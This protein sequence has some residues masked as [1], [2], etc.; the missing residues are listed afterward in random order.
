MK[1]GF[2]EMFI[3]LDTWEGGHWQM[4]YKKGVLKIL[5][6][7]V[8]VAGV[9]K[10]YYEDEYFESINWDGIEFNTVSLSGLEMFREIL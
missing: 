2:M 10:Y 1:A 5:R 4:V 9:K 7:H 3:E 6:L 8:F